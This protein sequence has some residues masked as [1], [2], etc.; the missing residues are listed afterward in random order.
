MMQRN[1]VLK[2]LSGQANFKGEMLLSVHEIQ[3]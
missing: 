3:T 1:G 2:V